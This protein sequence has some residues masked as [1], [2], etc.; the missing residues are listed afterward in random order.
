MQK[1]DFTSPMNGSLL[2]FF[3]TQLEGLENF[4]LIKNETRNYLRLF[5]INY[6]Q[7]GSKFSHLLMLF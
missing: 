1:H 7:F 2:D 6:D 5:L 4:S 3:L